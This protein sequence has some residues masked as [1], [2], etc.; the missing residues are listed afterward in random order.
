ML[1]HP[2]AAPYRLH[3]RWM[4]IVS[5]VAASGCFSPDKAHGSGAD[6]LATSTGSTSGGSSSA[7]GSP[8]TATSSS[9]AG[10]ESVDEVTSAS[11]TA[12]SNDTSSTATTGVGTEEST[13]GATT[14]SGS[15]SESTG[16]TGAMTG[17]EC[18]VPGDCPAPGSECFDAVCIDGFCGQNAA[19]V[20]AFCNGL[21]DQ[22]DGVGG[23]V[24]CVDNGGCGECCACQSQICV[25]V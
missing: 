1:V 7:E 22:C 3:M 21:E 11:A 18:T 8:T 17:D 24:D 5:L 23:C 25:P 20:G 16:S 10:Q 19:P 6:T 2:D 4:A 14:S 13:G 12:T 15:A 9:T